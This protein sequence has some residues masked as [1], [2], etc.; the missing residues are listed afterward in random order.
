MGTLGVVSLKNEVYET[1]RNLE[2]RRKYDETLAS[3]GNQFKSTYFSRN[4]P[5]PDP[6][7]NQR[8]SSTFFAQPRP[9][10]FNRQ[11]QPKNSAPPADSNRDRGFPPKD[12][13]NYFMTN[14]KR[15]V[16][17]DDLQYIG[18]IERIMEIRYYY[19]ASWKHAIPP[20]SC[21]TR[22]EGVFVIMPG[23]GREVR[24]GTVV[25]PSILTL[26]TMNA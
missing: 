15:F 8:F 7:S 23:L 2:A 1:L 14:F 10:S 9:H 13:Y 11:R 6:T 24:R 26:T 25:E 5:Q 19:N 4:N 20:A 3:S 21:Q 17:W 22:E 12:S 18:L 16:T